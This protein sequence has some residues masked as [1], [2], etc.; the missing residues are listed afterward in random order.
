MGG[1]ELFKRFTRTGIDISVEDTHHPQSG[2]LFEKFAH[3]AMAQ[4]SRNHFSRYKG[5]MKSIPPALHTFYREYDPEDVEVE[6]G[7][8]VIRF[9]PAQRL[10]Q[11]KQEYGY[12]DA[13]IVIAT[14]NGDPVFMKRGKVYTCPHGTRQPKIEKSADTIGEFLREIILEVISSK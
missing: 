10:S 3:T 6:Y 5:D 7:G 11:V 2:N 14:I 1:E 4:D 8:N 13:D 12:L 9:I